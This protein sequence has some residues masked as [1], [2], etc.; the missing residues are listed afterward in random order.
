MGVTWRPVPNVEGIE[1]NGSGDV[2]SLMTGRIRSLEKHRDGHLRV[3]VSGRNYFVHRL[4]YS[5]FNPA[6]CIDG[7]VIRHLNDVP[8]DNRVENLRSGTNRDNTLDMCR[9]GRH[10]NLQKTMCPRGHRLEAW[11]LRSRAGGWREC[12]SCHRA[13]AR[14]CHRGISPRLNPGEMKK[15]SDEIYAGLGGWEWE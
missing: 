5:A 4:V 15:V 6:E 7:K 14:L 12:I 13:Q 11:N 10:R 2:R 9:H 1:V 8:D 3:K